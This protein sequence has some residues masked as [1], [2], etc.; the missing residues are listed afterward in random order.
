MNVGRA[1]INGERL[2]GKDTREQ[3]LLGSDFSRALRNISIWRYRDLFRTYGPRSFRY[4]EMV[5]GNTLNV[6]RLTEEIPQTEIFAMRAP[7]DPPVVG[8]HPRYG[9]VRE[10]CETF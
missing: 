2:G 10:Y 6:R 5:F 9:A 1:V 7:A 4:A 8:N 3:Y